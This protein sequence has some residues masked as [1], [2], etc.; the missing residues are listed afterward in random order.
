MKYTKA[1]ADLDLPKRGG[2][3]TGPPWAPSVKVFVAVGVCGQ[4]IRGEAKGILI[5]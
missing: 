1:I 4:K 2:G 3:S 5:H